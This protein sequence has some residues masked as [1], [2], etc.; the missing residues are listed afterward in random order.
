[1]SFHRSL[2]TERHLPAPAA[3][4]SIVESVKLIRGHQPKLEQNVAEQAIV[5]YRHGLHTSH[6]LV[7]CVS[8]V[9]ATGHQAPA[10]SAG[11]ILHSCTSRAQSRS[12]NAAERINV[13]GYQPQ[14]NS[15]I[16]WQAGRLPLLSVHVTDGNWSK[17]SKVMPYQTANEWVI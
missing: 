10:W 14:P 3:Q 9:V 7:Q 16:D 8:S 17:D 4:Q 6:L 12:N 1:V 15:L 13:S 2:K 11:I 5:V